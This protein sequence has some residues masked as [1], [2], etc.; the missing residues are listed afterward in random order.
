MQRKY[1]SYVCC[2]FVLIE[3]MEE[4]AIQLVTLAHESQ[5]LIRIRWKMLCSMFSMK[6]C[7]ISKSVMLY[8]STTFVKISSLTTA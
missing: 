7:I 2:I 1:N 5:N 8:L 4:L 3:S 6:N